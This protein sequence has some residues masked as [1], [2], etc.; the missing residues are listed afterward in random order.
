MA[1]SAAAVATNAPAEAA[2]PARHGRDVYTWRECYLFD[3]ANIAGLQTVVD[4]DLQ[5]LRLR[6][7]QRHGVGES[8]PSADGHWRG[9]GSARAKLRREKLITKPGTAQH[10]HDVIVRTQTHEVQYIF[11]NRRDQ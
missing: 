6:F 9:N 5:Q 11:Y 7:R 4:G 8:K 3:E 1:G 10:C 2:P